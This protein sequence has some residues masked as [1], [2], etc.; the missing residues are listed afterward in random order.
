MMFF[1]IAFPACLVWAYGFAGG[2]DDLK[3][4][5]SVSFA[6]C[7]VCAAIIWLFPK[8]WT[9]HPESLTKTK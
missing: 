9:R 6:L 2:P 5:I 1:V 7:L 4:S 3:H 8:R